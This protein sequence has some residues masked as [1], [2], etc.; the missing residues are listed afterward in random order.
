LMVQENGLPDFGFPLTARENFLIKPQALQ[1]LWQGPRPVFILMD[2]CAR[3]GYLEDA[4]TLLTLGGKYLLANKAAFANR[5]LHL[6]EPSLLLNDE[7]CQ[8][9]KDLLSSAKRFFLY[10]LSSQW[11]DRVKIKGHSD[12]N[13]TFTR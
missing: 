5:N 2:E 1:E 8:P 10:V 7:P 12:S 4:V 9:P 3:V 13:D 11:G 6:A